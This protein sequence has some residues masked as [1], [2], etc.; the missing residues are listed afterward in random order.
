[1]VRQQHGLDMGQQADFHF[2]LQIG[3]DDF[4]L[5]L[6]LQG[7]KQQLAGFG[8]D[9]DGAAGFGAESLANGFGRG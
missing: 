1:V 6:G 8:L 2:F 3:V 5:F 4:F 7:L 9:V